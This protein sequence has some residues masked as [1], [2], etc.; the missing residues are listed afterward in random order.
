MAGVP[1]PL[2][3]DHTFGR[4]DTADEIQTRIQ[5]GTPLNYRPDGLGVDSELVYG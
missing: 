4:G 1:T 3:V 2:N 5:V